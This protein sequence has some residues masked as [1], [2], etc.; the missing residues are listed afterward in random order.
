MNTI[1][2]FIFG[3]TVCCFVVLPATTRVNAQTTLAPSQV[4][5]DL[6]RGLADIFSRGMDTLGDKLNRQ[7]YNARVYSTGGWQSVARHIADKYSRGQKDIVVLIGHSLGAD[8]TLRIANELNRSNIPI[9]L[10]VTFDA[11][12]SHQ[13]PKNVLHFVNFYQNNG[14]GKRISP[15]P[16]FQGEL[17]NV[18]LTADAN[19][20]HITI[21]K[22]DRLHAYAVAKIAEIVKKDLANKAQASKSVK[23]NSKKR[24]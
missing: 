13:V 21:D 6:F 16:G 15:G 9:E 10:I 4:Q 1:G 8:A 19:I 12:E 5:V 18:D 2:R 14:F 7:G 3:A 20:R 11:T 22:S 23:K 24:R 17:T